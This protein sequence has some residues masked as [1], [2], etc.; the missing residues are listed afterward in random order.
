[1]ILRR[2]L[3]EEL[4]FTISIGYD[5][6]EFFS[7]KYLMISHREISTVTRYRKCKNEEE[8]RLILK[9]FRA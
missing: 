7:T 8:F 5:I 2:F 9:E 4:V 6:Y 1:M 3:V